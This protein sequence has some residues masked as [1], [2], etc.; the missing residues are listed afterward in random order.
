MTRIF[1]KLHALLARVPSRVRSEALHVTIVFVAAFAAVA[2]PVVPALLHT[3]DLQT[4]KALLV[5]TIAA[6]VAA[7]LRAVRP[8]LFA[9]AKALLLKA[10][11]KT[12]A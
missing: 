8:R 3:P 12:A 11:G 9:D 7:G 2:A 10:L 4:V 1:R 5:A 6:G